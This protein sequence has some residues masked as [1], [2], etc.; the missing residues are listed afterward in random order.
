ML[1]SLHCWLLVLGLALGQA[2]PASAPAPGTDGQLMAMTERAN[3]AVTGDCCPDPTG[4]A[5]CM[6]TACGA[7]AAILAPECRRECVKVVAFELRAAP[8]H[9]GDLACADPPPPRRRAA[10]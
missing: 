6:V 10:A 2:A 8:T 9:A 5:D 3:P 1:R 4:S 7:C